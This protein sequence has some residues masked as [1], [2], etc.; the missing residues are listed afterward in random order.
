MVV[1]LHASIQEHCRKLG[2]DNLAP[3]IWYKIANAAYE[4]LL[5]K[6]VRERLYDA[7]CLILSDSKTGA[8]GVYHEPSAELCFRSFAASLIA[9]AVAAKSD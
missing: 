7:A 2:F 9:R 3:I 8:Q 1:P 5:T 4:V 6:L